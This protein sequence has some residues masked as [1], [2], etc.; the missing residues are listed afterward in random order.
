[1]A[2]ADDVSCKTYAIIKNLCGNPGLQK[3]T[4]ETFFRD[5]SPYC[6]GYIFQLAK[7]CFMYF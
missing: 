4:Q 3:V 5:F 7:I 6:F 1:M 2:L